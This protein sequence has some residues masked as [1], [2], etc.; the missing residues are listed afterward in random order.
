MSATFEHRPVLKAEVVDLFADVPAGLVVDATLGGGGHA[1][2]IL[3][4]HS[5]LQILGI[6][7]DAIARSAAAE[8]LAPFGDRASIVAGTFAQLAEFVEATGQPVV[9]VLFDLGVSSPQIDSGERGFSYM[10]QGPLDMRM[11]NSAELSADDVVNGYDVDDLAR[12]LREYGDERQARKVAQAIVAARPLHTTHA[13]A[14]VVRA[15]VTRGRGRGGDP[16]KRT[17]QAIRI[18][19]NAELDLLTDALDAAIAALVPAGRLVVISY[20]SGED[21]IVKARMRDGV[22]GGCECPPRLPC[23]CGATPELSLVW[24]GV[25]RPSSE[26]VQYNR[27]AASALLRAA[28]R[29]TTESS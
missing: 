7:R 6:D 9:G 24:S 25:R 21:R 12:I 23:V 10:C 1:A 18:E 14:D 27:R 15:A 13:L 2:A 29:L 28:T 4:A 17:F 20:H 26:E 3:H 16:S 11:D 19:V 8:R 22:T 5:H